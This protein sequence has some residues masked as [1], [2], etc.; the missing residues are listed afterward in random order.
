MDKNVY[1]DPMAFDEV[2]NWACG[3]LLIEIGKGDYR[4]ALHAILQVAYVQAIREAGVIAQ[5]VAQEALATEA[6]GKAEEEGVAT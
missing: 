6:N 2:W 5:N 1:S 4:T 3:Y